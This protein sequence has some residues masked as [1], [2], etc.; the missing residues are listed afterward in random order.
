MEELAR[1]LK[2]EVFQPAEA[3][4]LDTLWLCGIQQKTSIEADFLRGPASIRPM[5]PGNTKNGSIIL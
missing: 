4:E 3:M 5:L 2:N 1:D